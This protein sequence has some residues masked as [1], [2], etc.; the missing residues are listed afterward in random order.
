[1]KFVENYPAILLEKP[2]K[3]LVISDVHFGFEVELIE[4]GVKIPSQTW[5]I[6]ETLT[7][8]V[9]EYS[10]SK[11][12]VLGDLKHK[13]PTPSWIELREMP[14]ALRKIGMKNIEIMITPGNHDGGIMKILRDTVK[15][16]PSSGVL[17]KGEK[18]F[19]CFHGHRWPGREVVKADV[20]I[21]GHLH[22]KI[23]IRTDLGN[24]VKKAV[25][26]MIEG[27]KNKIA[28]IFR[29]KFDVD[30]RAR[31]KITMII[32]PAFNPL[33]TGISINELN[34]VEKL[35]P[36]IRSNIF[37]LNE[38]EVILLNGERLGRLK[39]LEMVEGNHE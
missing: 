25:W 24:I 16:A 35:W 1:L 30:V 28:K 18:R 32:M 2:E 22:P 31:G 19:F 14:E 5:K 7:T 9:E 34:P 11:L 12:L 21:T 37:K 38:S 20:I 17:I 3:I 10:P 15:Y 36:L 4:K 8:L 27:E 33:I 6:L 26:L 23:S 13:I 29:E 39:E